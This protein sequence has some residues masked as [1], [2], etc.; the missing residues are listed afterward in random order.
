MRFRMNNNIAFGEITGVLPPPPKAVEAGPS[1][2]L[3]RVEDALS[4]RLPHDLWEYG[5][6]YGTGR[7]VLDTFYLLVY[8]PFSATFLACVEADCGT[9][10]TLKQ[11]RSEDVPFDV[12]PERPGLLPLG[13]DV[14]GNMMFWLTE[15][16]PENWPVVVWPE[17]GD[18]NEYQRF[19]M[20]LTSFLAKL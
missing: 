2:K 18:G 13:T 3:A 5:T 19:E 4:I 10:R 11:S 12:F 8:N 6:R 9:L 16:E 14:N 7:I 20:P 1:G 17:G 15:G